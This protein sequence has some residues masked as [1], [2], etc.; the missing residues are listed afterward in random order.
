MALYYAATTGLSMLRKQKTAKMKTY[1]PVIQ[2][3]NE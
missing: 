1:Y 3:V 2:G